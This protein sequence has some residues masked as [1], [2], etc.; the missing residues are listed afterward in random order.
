MAQR[1]RNRA[2]G[3]GGVDPQIMGSANGC[4]DDPLT[5]PE[6]DP[7][8]QTSVVRSHWERVSILR[9]VESRCLQR[10]EKSASN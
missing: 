9:L 5:Q 1:L 10:E 2:K 8:A 7:A 4:G 6:D 3:G